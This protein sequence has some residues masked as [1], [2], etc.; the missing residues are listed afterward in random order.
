MKIKHFLNE[1]C[2]RLLDYDPDIVEIDQFGSSVY[3]PEYARD[4]D[5]LVITE[6]AKEYDG[7]LDIVYNVEPPVDIDV[8][9]VEP[10]AKLREE[11]L[12]GIIASFKPL[13]GSGEYILK[14]AEN[15]GDQTF[16]EAKVAL[17][18]AREYLELAERTTDPLVK[19]RHVRAAF[20][21]LF[22]ASRIASMTYLSTEVA[23]WGIIRRM[24]PEPY[25]NTFREFI[26]TLYVKY[27]Y[28]GQYPKEGIEK[29]FDKWYVKVVEFIDKLEHKAE[30]GI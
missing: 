24:L 22:H 17:K 30:E 29:E 26:D 14:L 25:Q 23:K 15:L 7:Y 12:R 6:K 18:A 19:D 21:S 5:L 2:K 1:V 8:I 27:F 10:N 28:H 20:D 3:A 16:N 11:L 9:V 4:I 13:H